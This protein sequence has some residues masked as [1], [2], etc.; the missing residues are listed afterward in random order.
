MQ[1]KIYSCSR[2]V[3]KNIEFIKYGTTAAGKQR[4]Q[5]TRCKRTSV[6][7]FTY[8]AYCENINSK[9]VKLTKEGAGIRSTARI[10]KISPTTLLKRIIEISANIVKPK[11]LPNQTYEVDEL[12]TYV[13]RKTNRFWLAYA[14][15]SLSLNHL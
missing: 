1:L 11:L 5:C 12:C 7:K 3:G 15:S 8:K 14:L 2:C 4:Y 9:I 13:K 10:L 6:L